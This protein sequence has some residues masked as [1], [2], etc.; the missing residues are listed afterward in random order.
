M[1]ISNDTSDFVLL[2]DVIP[3]VILEIRYYSTFNFIG[4]RING[5]EEPVAIITKE[6]AAQ[7]KKVNEIF[8]SEGY[9]I[10]VFDAFR[11]TRAVEHFVKW[12]ENKDDLRMKEYFYPD[13]DK[14]DL[15]EIGYICKQSSHSRGST[16]DMTLFDMKKGR[17][18]NMGTPFDYFGKRSHADF[19]KHLS[20]SEI[21]HRTFLT[22]TMK[23]NGFVM[24]N[25]EW[26]HFTLENEPFPDT[27][28][29]FAVNSRINQ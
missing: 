21:E 11:P 10:K 4:E 13:V 23:N 6:A 17:E 25:E 19:T 14:Q 12:A 27:Y 9:R 22:D 2:T 15:F 20:E 5:Y 29:D 24:I 16:V 28:F 3:E 1:S 7:L 26:W 18:V 8:M